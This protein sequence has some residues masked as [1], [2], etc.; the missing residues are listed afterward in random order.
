MFDAGHGKGAADAIG[1]VLKRTADRHVLMGHGIPNAAVMYAELS[2][3]TNVKLF[4]VEDQQFAEIKQQIPDGVKPIKGT[5]KL[6]QVCLTY[7]LGDDFCSRLQPVT[8]LIVN[9]ILK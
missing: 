2:H 6:H 5:M 1:G 4:F 9:S 3:L 7:Q 8:S